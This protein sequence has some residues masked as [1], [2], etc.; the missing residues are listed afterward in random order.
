MA[1]ELIEVWIAEGLEHGVVVTISTGLWEDF[2]D[3]WNET[4]P[5]SKLSSE[6]VETLET[7]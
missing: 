7:F 1:T 5:I 4:Y 2:S 6:S 3:F